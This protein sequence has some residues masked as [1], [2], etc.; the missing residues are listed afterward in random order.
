MA[1][2]AQFR[3]L[4]SFWHP[5][6]R[7][8]VIIKILSRKSHLL[9]FLQ[10]KPQCIGARL[11]EWIAVFRLRRCN[12]WKC[13]QRAQCFQHFRLIGFYLISNLFG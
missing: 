3:L 9:R 4:L 11:S 5:I 12:A 10:H 13:N 6:H 1:K 2:D 8:Y 7:T